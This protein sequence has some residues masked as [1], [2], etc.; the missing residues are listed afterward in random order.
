LPRGGATAAP[1]AETGRGNLLDNNKEVSR[2][3]TM[4]GGVA[5][6]R[7]LAVWAMILAVAVVYPAAAAP[8]Y[9]RAQA[10]VSV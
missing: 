8:M 7:T 4:A 10:S 3:Q 1:A 9:R 6:A 5:A 2:E